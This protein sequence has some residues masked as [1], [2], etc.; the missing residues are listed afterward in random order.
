MSTSNRSN[1]CKIDS[2]FKLSQR[3]ISKEDKLLRE[4][5]KEYRARVTRPE[6]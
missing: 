6:G 4:I 2:V 3:A 1:H 5:D